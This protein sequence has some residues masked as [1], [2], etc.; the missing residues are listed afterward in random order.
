MTTNHYFLKQKTSTQTGLYVQRTF[1]QILVFGM[2]SAYHCLK[3]PAGYVNFG[4]NELWRKPMPTSLGKYS[5]RSLIIFLLLLSGC[6]GGGGGGGTAATETILIPQAMSLSPEDT[7]PIAAAMGGIVIDGDHIYVAKG[8]AGI[9]ILEISDSRPLTEIGT[10]PLENG[11]YASQLVKA[12]NYLYLAAGSEGL[13]VVDVSNP[14]LPNTTFSDRAP[15]GARN[16]MLAGDRLFVTN[17]QGLFIYDIRTPGQPVLSGK[18]S[19]FFYPFQQMALSQVVS[20]GPAY[21]TDGGTDLNIVFVADPARPKLITT[22]NMGHKITAL[23]TYGDYLLAGGESNELYVYDIRR[24]LPALAATLPL[25]DLTPPDAS[26]TLIHRI[27]IQ[28][29]FAYIAD[30]VNGIQVVDI[31]E[32]TSPRIFATLA[33]TGKCRNLALD[34]DA[35]AIVNTDAG[36]ALAGIYWG[37]DRDADGIPDMIDPFPDNPAEWKDSDGDGIGNNA[38]PDDDND[39]ALDPDDA[40]PLD[41]AE[42]ADT[43]NDGYGDN[44]DA[45]PKDPLEWSDFDGDGYGNNEDVF[46][47]DPNEWADTD[48]DGIGNNSDAFPEDS[49]EWMDTDFDGI[50]DNKDMDDDGD[51]RTDWTD[52]YPLDTDNDGQE[53][54]ID[55][56]DDNDGH[57]DI[58]DAFPLDEEEWQDTNGD[59]LGD[60]FPDNRYAVIVTNYGTITLELFEDVAPLTTKNFIRLAKKG[61]YDGLLFHRVIDGFMIQGGDPDGNGTGGPGYAIIDEFP[62]DESGNLILTHDS[63]GMLSMAN[64]GPNTGGSQFFITLDATSWLDGVHSIFGHVVQGM[65]VVTTIGATKTDLSD[66]PVS[67]VIMESVT[68][69]TNP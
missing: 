14:G 52:T 35:L 51:G 56:D 64:S 47:E 36:I 2:F 48:R 23:A 40:F 55:P 62:T 21:I 6:G 3:N 46:P 57:P 27:V 4:A 20:N 8:D 24:T 30:G 67:D 12:G 37:D 11:G 68:I 53:N 38:D 28:D 65:G 31:Q 50:G 60:N 49:T 59:G 54:T 13:L 5:A 63:S 16:L 15:A 29:H 58:E 9:V 41:P 69:V 39:G 43:D 33:L 7:F 1:P 10:V 26:G 61:Y 18:L 45:F 17:N 66:K 22:I 19:A 44:R 42:Q 25:A 32:I 34:G